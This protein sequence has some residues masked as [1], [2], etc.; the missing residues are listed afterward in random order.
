MAT[1]TLNQPSRFLSLLGAMIVADIAW[2]AAKNTT[3]NIQ[4]VIANNIADRLLI[5]VE[6]NPYLTIDELRSLALMARE[7][8]SPDGTST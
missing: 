8:L 1:R 6:Q 4:S 7:L 2:E 3:G 5:S